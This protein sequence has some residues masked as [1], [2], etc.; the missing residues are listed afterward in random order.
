MVGA[1][2][3]KK[4]S[5]TQTHTSVFVRAIPHVTVQAYFPNLSLSFSLCFFSLFLFLL[6]FHSPSHTHTLSHTNTH[7]HTHTLTHTHS[8]R[9]AAGRPLTQHLKFTLCLRAPTKRAFVS[10]L[11]LNDGCCRA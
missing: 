11:R 8:L 10:K 6:S 1:W 5:R 7:T 3:G 9:T 4:N 2:L